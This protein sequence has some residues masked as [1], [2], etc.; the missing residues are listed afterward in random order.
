[1]VEL[2]STPTAET[3]FNLLPCSGAA[4]VW[5]KEIYFE[6][7]ARIEL[8]PDAVE[9]LEVGDVAFWPVSP[10][11]CVFFGKTPVS[12]SEKPRAYSPVNVFG[13]IVQGDIELLSEVKAGDQ[14]Q[15]NKIEA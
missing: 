2:R 7:D 14:I 6:I 11:F 15:V 12:T 10:V 5:G 8:E 9:E 1:M 3:I 13:R 4:H